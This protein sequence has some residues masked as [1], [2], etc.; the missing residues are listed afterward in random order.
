MIAIYFKGPIMLQDPGWF[1][2]L[3]SRDPCQTDQKSNLWLQ[4]KISSLPASG[5]S[6]LAMPGSRI[7]GLRFWV[8]ILKDGGSKL[9]A[10]CNYFH[11]M[12]QL[13]NE[14]PHWSSSIPSSRPRFYLSLVIPKV[15]LAY[16]DP[17]LTFSKAPY[18]RS[19]FP[20]LQWTS[21]R[22]WD[23]TSGTVKIGT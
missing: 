13:I 18:R 22:W 4:R 8:C 1:G 14:G 11:V 12:W 3:R 10:V 5:D 19:W 15:L 7:A 23:K 9:A 17:E 6:T 2:F 20:H 21:G 16:P